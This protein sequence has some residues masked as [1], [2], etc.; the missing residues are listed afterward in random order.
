MT[1][2]PM[3]LV[4]GAWLS[5]RS[6]ETFA[7]YFGKHGYA[8]SRRSGRGPR[9]PSLVPLRQPGGIS[10]YCGASSPISCQLAL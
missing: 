1:P 5:A 2:T 7:D 4:H 3:M 10:A 6:W 9:D 8:V